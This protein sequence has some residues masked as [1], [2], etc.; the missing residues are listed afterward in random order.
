M[1]KTL[2]LFLDSYRELNAKRLFWI[3]L[4]LNALV[5]LICASIGLKNGA[6]TVLFW[7]TPFDGFPF[8]PALLYK[9]MFT[10]LG[11]SIWLTWA[12]AILA[13]VSTT[14]IFPDFLASGSVDL[15]LSKPISRLWL[16]L[17]KYIGGLMFVTLQVTI[18]ALCSFLVLGIRGGDWEPRVFLSIPLVVAVFSFLFCFCVL[19][20]VITRS[21]ITAL[22]VTLLIWFALFGLQFTESLLLTMTT[23]HELAIES[24]E[25][26]LGE[27]PA[28]NQGSSTRPGHR[29]WSL[30]SMLP[31]GLGEESRT[32]MKQHL[33]RL[34][35]EHGLETTH[36]VFLAAVTVIPKTEVATDLL[37]RVLI[38]EDA[39]RPHADN[40]PVPDF[41]DDVPMG[42]ENREQ[43]EYLDH[44]VKKAQDS[45]GLVWSLGTSFAA[46]FVI[47][48]LAA[49]LFCR[50]DY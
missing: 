28:T 14:G 37:S 16:F 5:V 44:A 24:L 17:I 47:V 8:E 21:A 45:R 35:A 12:A 48:G 23:R 13:L 25:R 38:R 34:K 30:S 49:W 39:T 18:F 41:S 40:E 19:L 33:E 1:T 6:L 26:K 31:F 11:V 50:R 3:V 29:S 22:L 4:L 2:A 27:L 15:Y 42:Q 20:G 43:R 32:Q 46:E 9:Y 36:N 7:K 10:I